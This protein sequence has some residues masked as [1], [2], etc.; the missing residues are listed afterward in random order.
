MAL[1]MGLFIPATCA[2]IYWCRRTGHAV[3]PKL[4][5]CARSATWQ[6]CCSRVLRIIKHFYLSTS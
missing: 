6:T 2:Q 4:F 1:K 3:S 5:P